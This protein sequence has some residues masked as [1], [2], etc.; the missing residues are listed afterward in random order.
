MRT[1]R[2]GIRGFVAITAGALLMMLAERWRR[3]RR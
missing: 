3:R 2:V 1:R